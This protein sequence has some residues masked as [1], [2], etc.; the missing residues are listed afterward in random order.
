[1]RLAETG[2]PHK[3]E[4]FFRQESLVKGLRFSHHPNE[5]KQRELS[6]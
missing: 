5:L 1:M 3:M 6:P 4:L 2:V